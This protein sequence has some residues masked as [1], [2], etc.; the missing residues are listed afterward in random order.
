MHVFKWKLL[1]L[2]EGTE[3]F[4]LGS[5]YIIT[6]DIMMII[7]PVKLRNMKTAQHKPEINFY[8]GEL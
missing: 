6:L 7:G 4:D 1:A 3:F 8:V 5:L 2:V